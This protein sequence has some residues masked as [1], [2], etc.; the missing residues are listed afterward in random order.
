MKLSRE[1][2][3]DDFRRR[4]TN[5]SLSPNEKIG[6]PQSYR[7]GFDD[8]IIADI[9]AKLPALMGKNKTIIDIGSGCSTLTRRLMRMSQLHGHK[10]ILIDSEEML[11]QLPAAKG[12]IK[13][14]GYFPD[15]PNMSRLYGKA[16][17]VLVYSVIHY[18]FANDNIF[19]FLHTALTLLAPHGRL[20]MGDIPNST[21]R[22]RFLASAEGK[23]FATRRRPAPNK[24]DTAHDGTD[25][26]I[27][28]AIILSILSRVRSFGFEAYVMPQNINL[29]MAS[30]RE[31][32]LIER[33][34]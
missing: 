18:V 31:D 28:D 21:K 2:T 3:F 5:P 26:K 25:D 34:S 15:S 33:R 29:P 22:E 4:A 16:D 24:G 27:D 9:C 32:I 8:A 23:K 14:P 30:R 10:L 12:S 13:M 20:L 19:R 11:S 17:A 6:F 7:S 1:L